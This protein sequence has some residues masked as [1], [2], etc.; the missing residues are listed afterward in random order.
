MTSNERPEN[1]HGHG[2][3]RLDRAAGRWVVAASVV[4]SGAVFLESTVVNVALPPI[5][6]DLGLTIAALQWLVDGYLLTLSALMLLG[7]ALG[8]RFDRRRVF[9]VGAGAV[10]A[11]LPGAGPGAPGGGLAARPAGAG[12]A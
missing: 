8:D 2:G 6:R 3:L 4:G 12:G 11:S 9:V 1:R 5:G 7:G 10:A